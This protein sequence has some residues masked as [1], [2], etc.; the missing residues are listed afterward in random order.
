MI[1]PATKG[2]VQTDTENQLLTHALRYAELGYPVFPCLPN[3]KIPLTKHGLND[4]TTDAEQIEKWWKENPSA[5]I[6]LVTQGLFVVDIDGSDNYWPH[7][8]N[9]ELE[10]SVGITSTTPRGGRHHIFRQ[11]AGVNWRNTA[12]K[13]APNVDTRANGGYIVVAPSVIGGKPYCWDE[14]SE[15][16]E[17]SQLI[18]PP[19]W[20]VNSLNDSITRGNL[21]PTI[22]QESN[23][24]PDGQRNDTLARYAGL[25][26][27]GDMSSLEIN[28]ALQEINKGRCNP[29]LPPSEVEKIAVSIG[30]YPPDQ[31]TVATIE[32]HWGQDAANIEPDETA[33]KDP[34]PLPIKLLRVPGFVSQVM[35]CC[36]ESAPYPNQVLAFCGALAL[37]SFLAGR[38][39]R[40]SGDCRTNIYLLGLAHSAAGKDQPRKV[41]T[42]V[43]Q[44]I[45]QLCCLANE[46]ASGEGLQDA[47]YMNP[48]MLF[49]TDEIDGMLQSINR[50]KDARH[51]AKLG[52]MLTVYSSANNIFPMRRR[53]GQESA[54]SINQPCL[55]IFGTAIPAHYYDA[56][57]P[58][59]LTNGFFSRTM[60]FEGGERSEG[61]EPKI[62][63]VPDSVLETAKWWAN[64]RP[65]TGNLEEWSPVPLVVP[66]SDAAKKGLIEMRKEADNEY[67]QCESK[68]DVVG[69]T[70]WG[71]VTENAC[72]L[73]LIYAASENHKK[74]EISSKAVKWS[75]KI[76]F[77]QARRMLFMAQSH[78]SESPFDDDCNKVM[79]S[80]Q[81]APGQKLS[82]SKLLREFRKSEKSLAEVTNT[83]V[84]SGRIVHSEEG[85]GR[86]KTKYYSIPLANR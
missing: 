18:E 74:P 86:R 22:I 35:D 27:R 46:F 61:Q 17:R 47:L 5:N 58:R 36:L 42:K 84:M 56:L 71:R 24:I 63:E 3:G 76:T 40:D 78:V 77:H 64:F 68:N 14:G 25:M 66:H 60:I 48:A 4:A 79:R 12:S 57:S 2:P 21:T 9:K 62:I 28:A 53:A 16:C 29:P 54:D 19:A 8:A 85:E 33:A 52:T 41:N 43:L 30:R 20:I 65:G 45:G 50:S 32:N 23:P 51:E 7:D 67:K 81:R 34:G 31:I 72:K 49:Q 59:L 69:T 1:N 55:T 38:K 83:L 10:L 82:K 75:K 73:A 44:E 39:V 11:P 37:Q 6:G 13:I 80:I 15:L 26:R 70:V